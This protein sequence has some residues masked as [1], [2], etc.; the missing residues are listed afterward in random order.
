[1]SPLAVSQKI[2]GYAKQHG[3][4][5]LPWKLSP[6][7]YRVWV[8]EVM[9]QQTQV[10]TVVGYFEQFMQRFPDVQTL[11]QSPIDDVLAVWSGL[12]YYRRAHF[13]HQAAQM[14]VNDFNGLFPAS[15]DKLM[16]LP[17][18][19]RSTA[20]AILSQAM[21]IPA[22]IL[23]GNVKRVLCRYYQ[24]EGYPDSP[25]TQKILWAHSECWTPNQH[26]DLYTQGVMDLGANICTKKSPNCGACPI[27]EGCKSY[28]TQTT[29]TYPHPKPYK[30][31]PTR[32]CLFG[33][34]TNN[35]GQILLIKRPKQGIWGGLWSLPALAC[36]QSFAAKDHP[37]LEYV[38]FG[39]IGQAKKHAFTH[40]NLEYKP[41]SMTLKKQFVFKDRQ[42]LWALP[43]QALTLG[44]PVPIKK[45]IK[46][47]V[48]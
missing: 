10:Q 24:V 27:Q 41:V 40:F 39:K 37:I 13:L 33:I 15:V 1:M 20:G 28:Q 6:T 2:I 25:K 8:S 32:R 47:A 43:Q 12:G 48:S 42:V 35:R 34:I 26:V 45:A 44:L 11:A 4:F 23:D 38:E 5:H 9:L 7:P 19:G 18:I 17:G 31:K 22:P 3:R 29:D 16:Q 30:P 46:G 14:I 36:S 21:Q